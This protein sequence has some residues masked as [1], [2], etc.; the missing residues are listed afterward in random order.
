MNEFG[1]GAGGRMPSRTGYLGT[2]CEELDKEEDH[3]YDLLGETE[4]SADYSI[5]SISCGKSLKA[6]YTY[7]HAQMTRVRVALVDQEFR[8][9]A[10]IRCRNVWSRVTVTS[11]LVLHELDL[12]PCS[13]HLLVSPPHHMSAP[14]LHTAYHMP[15]RLFSSSSPCTNVS[16]SRRRP[17]CY[18][19]PFRLTYRLLRRS[20]D[21]E[22]LIPHRTQ[23]RAWPCAR[24][25]GT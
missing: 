14:S 22:N 17:H 12:S 11:P 13:N 25:L 16:S 7:I 23:P 19:L 24:L 5:P 3:L 2:L 8:S 6:S 4:L 15:N 18:R 21:H 9:L 10:G 20:P 1:L